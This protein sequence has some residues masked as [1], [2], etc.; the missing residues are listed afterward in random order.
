M[1]ST[2]RCGGNIPTTV[3]CDFFLKSTSFVGRRG[4]LPKCSK[5][6][7]RKEFQES[8]VK[9]HYDHSMIYRFFKSIQKQKWH[10]KVPG[11]T[12]GKRLSWV[13]LKM[14][15]PVPA[16][17]FFCTMSK[18]DWKQHVSQLCPLNWEMFRGARNCMST[19]ETW[20]FSFE[21]QTKIFTKT[22]KRHEITSCC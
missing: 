15:K 20:T 21:D 14:E 6:C 9:I 10:D 8:F 16:K 12:K 7:A 2:E 13:V 5:D 1:E 22:G 3:R 11:P 17:H 18:T 19:Q 4:M